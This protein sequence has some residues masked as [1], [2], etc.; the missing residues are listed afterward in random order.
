MTYEEE[1]KRQRESILNIAERLL[2]DQADHLNIETFLQTVEF[3]DETK[4]TLELAR[5]NFFKKDGH[6][7]L[8]DPET[9]LIEFI[10]QLKGELHEE[11]EQKQKTHEA[12]VET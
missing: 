9:E 5:I 11:K 7:G 1:L 8:L 3:F 2:A 10:S 6:D 4:G 12:V